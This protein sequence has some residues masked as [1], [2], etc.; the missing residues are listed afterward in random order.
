M[1][2]DILPYAGL[3]KQRTPIFTLSAFAEKLNQIDVFSGLPLPN[4]PICV[5]VLHS[6]VPMQA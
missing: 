3:R 1:I 6:S 4:G 2:R 5:C